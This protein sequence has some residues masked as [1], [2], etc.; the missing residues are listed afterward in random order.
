M[1]R[2]LN[3]RGETSGNS[4]YEFK[5]KY[6]K[7]AINLA[8]KNGHINVLEW[9]HNSQHE[10]KYSADAINW[11]AENGHINVL[12]WFRDSKLCKPECIRLVP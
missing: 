1:S 7:Y 4:D 3:Q 8:A 9:F 11:A 2:R 10:F 12:E 6:S 5:F